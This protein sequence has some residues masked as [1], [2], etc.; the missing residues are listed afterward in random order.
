MRR[1]HQHFFSMK[2]TWKEKVEWRELETTMQAVEVVAATRPA[3][4]HEGPAF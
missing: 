3:K 2:G 1:I 4:G